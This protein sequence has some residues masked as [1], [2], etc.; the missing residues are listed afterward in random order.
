MKLGFTRSS[1]EPKLYFKLVQD[2]PSILVLYVDDLFLT[3]IEPVMIEFKR[4]LA[5]EFE[6][7]DLGLMHYFLGLEVWQRPGETF[8]SQGKYIV[9]LLE[10]FEM[11]KCKSMFTPMEMNFKK[12]CGEAAGPNLKNPSKYRQLIG[13]LMFLA[14]THLDIC[15]AVN[16]LSQFMTEPLHAQWIATKHILRNLHGLI[17]LGLRYSARDFQ[18]HG[19]NDAELDENVIN[20]KSTYGCFFSLG[21]AM[22]SWMS[23]K[24]NSMA[25]STTEVEYIATSMASY[26]EFWLINLFGELFE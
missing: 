16:T 22:I 21:F 17:T 13:A 24:Q 14:N 5:Y 12:L 25:L 4:K 7:K 15:Y 23:K 19:Y 10:I 8:L 11:T 20:R 9:K 26:E 2:M 3:G 6:L 1:A 18:L